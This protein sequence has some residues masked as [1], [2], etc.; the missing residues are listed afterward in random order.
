MKNLKI[1]FNPDNINGILNETVC[2][3]VSVMAYINTRLQTGCI[4]IMSARLMF[5]RGF[6]SV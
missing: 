4:P 1:Y 2:N 3:H 6:L 5:E